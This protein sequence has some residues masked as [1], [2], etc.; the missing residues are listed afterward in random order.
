MRLVFAGTPAVAVPSLEALVSSRHEVVGVVTRPD[1][2]RGRGATLSPS[3][4]GARAA[5]LGLPVLKPD[6]PRDADFR[7]ALRALQPDCCPV[8]AYGALLPAPLLHIP[9]H[10]WINLH[11]S[12]LP[13][14]R[15]A[16]PV[17]TAILHGE[18]E[19]G[20]VTF[21]IVPA[22]D[23]GPVCGEIRTPIG[24]RETAGELLTRLAVAG[25]DLLVETMDRIEDGTAEFVDQPAEAWTYAAKIGVEDAH[26][27]WTSPVQVVD[28]LI[29]ACTPAP[30]AWTTLDGQR[31]RL[32]EVAPTDRPS[33]DPGLVEQEGRRLY[34]HTGSGQLELLRVQPAGKRAMDAVSW[35]N[36]LHADRIRLGL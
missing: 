22:L 25:A 36:G 6:H 27:D 9:T 1:A 3:P 24:A 30:G 21:R 19:T 17:Q 4:V 7:A 10:G 29:R 31:F 35:A 14:Y 34:V 32:H 20:A 11:F 33:T 23:A 13:A 26:V 28:R 16:A 12:L 5:E 15:G 8:V 18:A 2:R